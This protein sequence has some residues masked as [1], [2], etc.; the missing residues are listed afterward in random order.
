[1]QVFMQWLADLLAP[2]LLPVQLP[3]S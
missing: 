1:V 3:Q 2:R